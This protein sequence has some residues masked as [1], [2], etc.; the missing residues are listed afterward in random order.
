MVACRQVV[1]LGGARVI[2]IFAEYS[3]VVRSISDDVPPAE[4]HGIL[5]GMICVGSA[6]TVSDWLAEFQPSAIAEQLPDT[7]PGWDMLTDVFRHTLDELESNDCRFMPLLP[8]D[9]QPLET[10][11]TALRDWCAGFLYGLGT[12]SHAGMLSLSDDALE[13][14][15]DITDLTRLQLTEP[16]ADDEADIVDLIEYLR[17]GV[18]FLYEELIEPRNAVT[19]QGQLLH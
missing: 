6:T 13:M 18:M 9:S 19:G 17:V 14:V 4:F 2:P 15:S 7:A 16:K 11:A 5:S 10:R 1:C 8:E 3:Q 12:A